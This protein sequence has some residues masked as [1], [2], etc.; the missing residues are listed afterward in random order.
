MINCNDCIHSDRTGSYRR[1]TLIE[2]AC[3]L[4]TEEGCENLLWRKALVLVPGKA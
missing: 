1:E 2:T 4:G 3:F